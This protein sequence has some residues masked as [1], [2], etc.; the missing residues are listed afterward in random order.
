MSFR[1]CLPVALWIGA[2]N[3]PLQAQ[4][5][6]DPALEALHVAEKRLELQRAAADRLA[7]RPDDAQ[8]VLALALAAMSGNDDAAARG[9]A[10][11]QARGCAERQPRA[12]PCQY[13]LGMLLGVQ[14]MSEGMVA[15]ARSVGTVKPH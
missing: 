7:A 6:M 1:R 13:A 9:K 15:M 3:A 5:L 4:T 10:L 11:D 2:L 14:A 12:A 8:A